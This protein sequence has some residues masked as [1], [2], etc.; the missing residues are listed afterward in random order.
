MI[1]RCSARNKGQSPV[2]DRLES[3]SG[4]L[5]SFTNDHCDDLKMFFILSALV[6]LYF[7]SC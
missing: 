6:V 7:F 1:E 5:K 4:R 3:P 2:I